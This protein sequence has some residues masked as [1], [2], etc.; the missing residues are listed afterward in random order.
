MDREPTESS[1]SKKRLS[2][3]GKK[4][5]ARR[6]GKA[7]HFDCTVVK[8]H[9]D[10]SY[11]IEY[12][13][14]H[15]KSLTLESISIPAEPGQFVKGQAI[16]ARFGGKDKFYKGVI[17]NDNMDG[18]YEVRY[19]DG[20]NEPAVKYIRELPSASSS[21]PQVSLSVGQEVQA[22][23]GGKAEH[24][25]GKIVRE[26]GDG[27]FE[28]RYDDG[29]TEK[30]VP[31]DLISAAAVA[32]QFAVGEKIEARFG[33]KDKYY[34]GVIVSDNLDGTYQVR[35]AD[36]DSEQDVKYIRSVATTKPPVTQ[37]QLSQGQ[38]VQ[39][40]FGG[41]SKYCD[42]FVTKDNGDGTY[43]VDEAVFR[44]ERVPFEMISVP[45][46]RGLFKEGQAVE[47]RFGGKDKYFKGVVTRWTTEM[48]R[49]QS[50]TKMVTRRTQ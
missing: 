36:G 44:E 8:D 23:F 35:Y 7:K 22:R 40:R 48:A 24:Y 30:K 43:E 45:A 9:G 32:G 29:D 1:Q 39:A 27:T 21:P 15:E 2:L 12:E 10:G 28:I 17:M 3:E 33:G 34:S 47:A 37:R 11:D 18:T 13:Q 16:E 20:D 19:E 25:S 38:K 4:V 31:L 6:D 46:T 5:Q 41:Q 26:N 50:D 49:M 42:A 14:R